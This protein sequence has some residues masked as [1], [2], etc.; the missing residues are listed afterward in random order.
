MKPHMFFC[1]GNVFLPLFATSI[2]AFSIDG[3]TSSRHGTEIKTDNDKKTSQKK[4]KEKHLKADG[5][6]TLTHVV[7]AC[8]ELPG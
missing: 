6:V 7:D 4:F 3:A 2:V 1:H 8:K 5:S